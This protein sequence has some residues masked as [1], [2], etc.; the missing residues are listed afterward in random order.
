MS[1]KLKLHN[2]FSNFGPNTST[3]VFPTEVFPTPIRSSCHGI[4]AAMGKVGAAVGSYGF[5]QWV[6]VPDFGFPG[7][8]FTFAFLCF[9]TIVL[10]WIC[11]Y[12]NNQGMDELDSEFNAL[13]LGEATPLNQSIVEA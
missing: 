4:S 8:F 7:V 1:A 6:Q 11:L 3:F 5:S 10:T 2:F 9:V 12:D 13:V